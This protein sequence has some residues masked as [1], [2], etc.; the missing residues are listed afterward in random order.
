MP[1]GALLQGSKI[2]VVDRQ[3]SLRTRSVEVMYADDEFYYIGEGLDESEEVVVSAIGAP[4]EGLKL[5]VKN[6]SEKDMVN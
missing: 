5:R 2:A 6:I 4:I 1:R 3:S